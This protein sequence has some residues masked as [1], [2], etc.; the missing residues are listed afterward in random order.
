MS[1]DYTPVTAFRCSGTVI[2]NGPST[3]PF[4]A[5][6]AGPVTAIRS[7]PA[8]GRRRYFFGAGFGPD[9]AFF[10]AF[11]LLVLEVFFGLLSPIAQSFLTILLA[12]RC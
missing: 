1:S 11:C 10:C 5:R 12:H 3:W 6:E 8:A 9:A 7:G 4:A 2:P